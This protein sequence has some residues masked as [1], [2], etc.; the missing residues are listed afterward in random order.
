MK[1]IPANLLMKIET[2]TTCNKIIRNTCIYDTI[3]RYNNSQ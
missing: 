1:D 2:N 3:T